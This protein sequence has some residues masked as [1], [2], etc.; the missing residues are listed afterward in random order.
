MG[1]LDGILGRDR[2]GE[3][4]ERGAGRGGTASPR[5]RVLLDLERSGSVFTL[6]L[7]N[8]GD[9]PAR[10]VETE[11]DRP[12]GVTRG[13]RDVTEL[14]VF[15]GAPYAVP[16]KRFEVFLGTAAELLPPEG[17]AP[18]IRA[19]VTYRGSGGE[20]FREDATHDPEVYR[21]L[22]RVEP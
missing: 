2:G 18:E 15:T 8:H 12:L 14:P 7:E 9:A 19:T 20:R 5:P 6:V 22:G 10:D 4:G 17:E 1:W 21:D 3:G 13:D 16:G 11:F